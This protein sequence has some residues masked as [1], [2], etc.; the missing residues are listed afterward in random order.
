MRYLTRKFLKSWQHWRVKHLE[1]KEKMGKRVKVEMHKNV[2]LEPEETEAI[3]EAIEME[4]A[5]EPLTLNGAHSNPNAEVN[6]AE[7]GVTCTTDVPALV[8]DSGPST[9]MME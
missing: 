5:K 9:G 8:K 7:S 6:V 2:M 4:E 1:L 3:K